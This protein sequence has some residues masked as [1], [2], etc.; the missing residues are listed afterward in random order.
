MN[1]ANYVINTTAGRV[2]YKIPIAETNSLNLGL[3]LEEI[4]IES[5]T[6]GTPREFQEVIDDTFMTSQATGIEL[7]IA[8][9]VS[10]DSRN[11]FFFPTQGSSRS[12]SVELAFPG[13]EYE[14]Y[15]FNLQNTHYVPLPRDFAAKTSIR[16]GFGDGFGNSD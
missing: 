5:S 3:T 2:N 8:L 15:K 12:A 9:G 14:Y 7:L 10:K 11:D 4:E 6:S 1:S 13:S 16:F